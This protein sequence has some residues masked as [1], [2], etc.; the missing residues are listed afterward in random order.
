MAD[1]LNDEN[2]K[3]SGY[4]I[5]A[6]SLYKMPEN[7]TLI[8]QD[9]TQH[10]YKP[11]MNGR[12]QYDMDINRHFVRD[13]NNPELR[14]KPTTYQYKGENGQVLDI[15][16]FSGSTTDVNP[17]K[18]PEKQEILDTSLEYHNEKYHQGKVSPLQPF[19]RTDPQVAHSAILYTYN[20]T[21]L[22]VADVEWRKG[23][24]HIFFTRPE[25]Y[26]MC[27]Q[28]GAIRLCQQTESDTDFTSTYSRMPHIIQLLAPFY[29]TGSF[30]NGSNGGSAGLLTNWNYL[31]SNR[32]DGLN[33]TGTTMSLDEGAGRSYGGYSI[34]LGSMITS[35]VGSTIDVT[36]NETK[37]LECYE[38][39]RMWM[40]YITK[41][42]KGIFAPSF[43]GYQYQNGFYNP[44]VAVGTNKILHPYD[45]AL[46][47]AATMF[48]IIT[49]EAGTKILY[50]CKYYGI[51]PVSAVPSISNTMNGPIKDVKTT[52][53]YRYMYKVENS[54]KSLLEFN[55]NAGVV[56]KTGKLTHNVQQSLPFLLS[57]TDDNRYIG[58][59]GMFTGSP[60]IVM[61]YDT[62]LDT[63]KR[64]PLTVP[65]L[66]FANLDNANINKYM[67][68]GIVNNETYIN[69]EPISL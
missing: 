59:A 48:D 21:K 18:N 24:R 16:V 34:A 55:Y 50:W 60:Y 47:Y 12:P 26:V 39:N 32:V 7:R 1:I 35:Q 19:T 25:C 64:S 58:A 6:G 15:P 23:F 5:N 3:F 40:Q 52:V 57:D 17:L 22:P 27:N 13:L 54:N 51:I 46:D 67:N 41:R 33:P 2:E 45:R 66:R 9:H 43:N 56:S 49:N 62:Q 68:N 42:R 28:G 37:N 30:E 69:M 53:Q 63:L 14:D 11:I 10:E 4:N 36:F 61:G 31:L 20:R 44:G 65:Y 8:P 29:I 38:Y